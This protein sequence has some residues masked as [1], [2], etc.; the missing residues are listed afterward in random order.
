[1]DFFKTWIMPPLV[2]AVIGYFTNWLAIKMLFR[3]LKPVYVGKFKLP[4]TPGILPRERL[5]L[6]DS[7]G[8]TVSREL[9]TPEVFKTR[10]DEPAL[11]AKIEEAIYLIIG[12][13]LDGEASGLA[14]ALAGGGAVEKFKATEAGGLV[15]HSLETVLRSA[16]FRLALAE[17]AGR[18]AETA[19]R[20]P[21]GSF[22]PAGMVREVAERF[23][24]EWGRSDRREMMNALIDGLF[25]LPLGSRPL[26]SPQTLS[27]LIET[28][29][30]S[31]FS[32]VLP[33]VEKILGSEA[34][35]ADLERAGRDIV[36]KAIGRLG[37]LQR[38]IVSAANYE[39][40][41]NEM[42]P[43]TIDDVS[44]TVIQLLRSADMVDK[45]VASVLSYALTPRIPHSSA[46]I[47]GILPLPEL[48]KALG[49]FFSGMSLEKDNFAESVEQRYSTIA[50][51]S[52]SELMPGL[53]EAL[54][55]GIAGSLSGQPQ[56]SLQTHPAA[57]LFSS[58][59]QDFFLSYA[60]RIEGKTAGE[61]LGLGN[62]EKRA[63]SRIV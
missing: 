37:P 47:A 14:K 35:K 26:F 5:R 6:S 10:L 32:S 58:S 8:E 45:I 51:K 27:P 33:V 31:L 1:M 28:G 12:D 39:K 55:R 54:A 38:L 30:R 57:D 18:A 2:G 61:I 34:V 3:P 20:I 62:E 17:A 48:K 40:T 21:L 42:M 23:A 16:E 9:L 36:K 15:A 13:F 60:Q 22:I 44:R 49:Q 52:L 29:T 25:E 19:G 7:V 46:P 41:L 63:I 24:G 4:F 56:P 43:D 53:P 59:F 50:E 11:R